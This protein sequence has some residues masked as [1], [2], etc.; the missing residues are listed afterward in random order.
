M[1]NNQKWILNS[2]G[3]IQLNSISNKVIG[4]NSDKRYIL[5]DKNSNNAIKFEAYK[6]FL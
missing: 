6:A 2:D 3:Y 1:N 4:I 5:V